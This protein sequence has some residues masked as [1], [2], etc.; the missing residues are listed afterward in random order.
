MRSCMNCHK[1]KCGCNCDRSR[2]MKRRSMRKQQKHI[3]GSRSACKPGTIR[4]KGYSFVRKGKTVRV[5][6]SCIKDRGAKGKGKKL[7]TLKK[8]HLSPFG[9]SLKIGADSRQRALK[10]VLKSG[11]YNENEL[12]R[13]INALAV[14][15][16]NTKPL[17]T[18]R[19][20]MDMKFLRKIRDRK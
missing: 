20:Q 10:K 1:N 12:I 13:K 3:G 7:F 16:K 6:S 19:A 4:R 18:R 5:K 2:T 15:H 8:G 11:K 14:L 9:Y 17:Y